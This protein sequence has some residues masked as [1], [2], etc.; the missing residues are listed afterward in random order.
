MTLFLR[1]AVLAQT[2]PVEQ[3]ITVTF[4]PSQIFTILIVGLIA[5]F[6]ANLL[7]R[8][9][10][11]LLASVAFGLVGA[12]VG[13][14]LFSAFNIQ[15][16]AGGLELTYRDLIASFVGAVLVLII[17]VALFGRRFR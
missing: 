2:P 12:I 7:I 11:G 17:V 8:G 3:P 14:L 15:T 1:L 13:N 10:G 6:F 5:G 4:V 16:P 9:R